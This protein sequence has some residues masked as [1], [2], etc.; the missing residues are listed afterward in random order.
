MLC[1]ESILFVFLFVDSYNIILDFL[2]FVVVFNRCLVSK[3]E[4]KLCELMDGVKV[5]VERKN[6][7]VLV[8]FY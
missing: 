1:F 8:G 3:M 5:V 2:W 4:W 6:S 7:K